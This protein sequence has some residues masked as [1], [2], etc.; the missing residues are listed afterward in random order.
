MQVVN[1]FVRMQYDSASFIKT[2]MSFITTGNSTHIRF[3]IIPIL[4]YQ[5]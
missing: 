3:F 1:Y 4:Q 5:R 2:E